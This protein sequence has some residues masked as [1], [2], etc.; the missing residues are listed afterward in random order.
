MPV[1]LYGIL[2]RFYFLR[3]LGEGAFQHQPRLSSPTDL[4][5]TLEARSAGTNAECC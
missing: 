4:T 3:I 1:G 2:T 5:V